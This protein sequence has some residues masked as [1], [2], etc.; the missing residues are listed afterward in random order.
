MLHIKF[1]FD[2]SSGFREDFLNIMVIA[3]GMG[4]DESLESIF[5]RI[6]GSQS[7]STFPARFSLQKTF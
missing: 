6:I 5:F 2:W 4:S 1:H 3:L 7:Y